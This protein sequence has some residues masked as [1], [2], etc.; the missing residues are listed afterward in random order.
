MAPPHEDDPPSGP[1]PPPEVL[2]YYALGF[3]RDRLENDTFA[4]E[5]A[6][7]Q[8]LLSR[9]LPPPP[10]RVLDV[11]G[12]A[13][14]Y[15]TWLAA[16]GYEVHLVDPVPL[17][18]EQARAASAAQPD[19]PLASIREGDAR[20]LDDDDES[21]DAVL[22]LG[23][24]YHLTARSE[25]L[26]ALAEARRVL[27]RGGWLFAA[28]ISRFAS[29]VDGLRGSV[30]DDPAFPSIVEQDLASGQHRNDTGRPEYF[31]TAFFHH[32]GELEE[33]IVESGF[34]ETAVFAV[35]GVGALVPGFARRWKEPAARETLLS[36]LRLVERETSLAGASPHLL[37][38]AR[39]P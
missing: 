37:A 5:R 16:A 14:A 17:H 12:G 7:T 11:G 32:R 28:A 29:L 30:F 21:A 27:R 22:M 1:A 39:R 9:H 6:R 13:G 31:T 3:E 19:A 34:T 15:A 23:P 35:E 24:L 10:A 2:R 36:L 25:R 8:E 18:L 38:V 33:E 4:L 26:G 20:R